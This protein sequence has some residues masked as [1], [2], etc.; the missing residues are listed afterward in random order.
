MGD[1]NIN[2]RKLKKS[3]NNPVLEKL[4]NIKKPKKEFSD[5]LIE[6]LE[7]HFNDKWLFEGVCSFRSDEDTNEFTITA[8][9]VNWENDSE[10]IIFSHKELTPEEM[11][12]DEDLLYMTINYNVVKKLDE[13]K[14][15]QAESKDIIRMVTPSND[16]IS[17]ELIRKKLNTSILK[18]FNDAKN[19]VPRNCMYT[20]PEFYGE[21]EVDWEGFTESWVEDFV[22]HWNDHDEL[23]KVAYRQWIMEWLKIA[24]NYI[25]EENNTN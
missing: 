11:E 25:D 18:H 6:R 17:K 10:S 14:I 1:V 4:W 23:W 15:S 2:K 16:T 19:L 20:E 3:W 12:L 24:M 22:E 21:Y 13:W 8:H 7:E 5:S 9:D